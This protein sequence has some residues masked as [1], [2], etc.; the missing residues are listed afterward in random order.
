MKKS[1]LLP[2]PPPLVIMAA[3]VTHL[4]FERRL[5]FTKWLAALEAAQGN[6]VQA[7]L[8]A[9]P[10]R[11]PARAKSY[12]EWLTRKFKLAEYATALRVAAGQK[13]TGRPRSGKPGKRKRSQGKTT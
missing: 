10:E 1:D 3:R 11:E 9:F 13:E 4:E 7:G 5:L 6:V 8:A 2:S 12:G